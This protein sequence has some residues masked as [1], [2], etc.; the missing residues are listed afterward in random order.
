MT[1]PLAGRHGSLHIRRPARS[2][3]VKV[4]PCFTIAPPGSGAQNS[5]FRV[6]EEFHG[7]R[8]EMTQGSPPRS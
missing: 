1:A 3:V 4:S 6:F 8:V 7:Q 5:R 2:T